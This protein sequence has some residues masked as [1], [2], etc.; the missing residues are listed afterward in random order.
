MIYESGKLLIFYFPQEEVMDI[1]RDIIINII[2]LFGLV[3]VISLTSSS[4]KFKNRLFD[5]ILGIVIGLITI[6]IMMN[7]W[8]MQNIAF[9]DTRTVMLSVTALF[10]SLTTSLVATVF[11]LGYR[12]YIGGL[13]IY[14]GVTSIIFA[15]LVGLIW[16][17]Y[18]SKRLKMNRYL[19]LYL[20]GFLVQ[21]FTLFA[22]LLLPYPLSIEVITGVGLIM[23]LFFPIATMLLGTAILN[24]ENR[25][26]GQRIIQVSERKYRSLIDSSHLGIIQFNEFGVIEIANDAF[27]KMLSTSK[28]RLIGLKQFSLPNKNLVE[29]VKLCLEGKLSTY[30]DYYTSTLSGKTFPAKIQFSPI[31]E[32][33]KV[34][35]GIGIVED[36]TLEY[37]NEERI[38]ELT[39][40]DTLTKICNRATFDAYIF[41]ETRLKHHP[42]SIAIIDI[43]TFQIINT[44]FGYEVGNQVLIQVARTITD[45]IT[46]YENTTVYRT[47]GDEFALVI[48]STERNKAEALSEKIKQAINSLDLFDFSLNVSFGIDT[49]ESKDKSLVEAY[50]QALVNLNTSK[51]YD[52][53]SI[54]IKTI[55]VIMAT[56]F[57]K[58]VRE[59]NHSERVSQIARSIAEVYNLGTAFTNRVELAG[60]L[61][62]IGKINI[63]EDILDKPGRLTDDERL[64]INKHPESGFKILS[65]VSE[66]LD[67]ANIVLSHHE[68]Y[69]GRGY[70]NG[71]MGNKIPL[72]SRIIGVA[73]AFD[74]MTEQRTYRKPLTMGEAIKEISDN[75]G[76]QFDPGVVDKFMIYI[77]NDEL[78]S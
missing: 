70:P 54:S 41:N 8:Q 30:K 25:I 38:K 75:K 66:Y 61:H 19:E 28:E 44:S 18:I 67:I 69:D 3:F 63:S 6:V 4:I 22:Q 58:S 57:E 48:T 60:R 68:R 20:F 47:G 34:I 1:F 7:A 51:I 32:N 21:T 39:Q 2:L 50:N 29:K 77:K 42:V 24:H 45:I 12:I 33:E 49:V 46:P 36:L 78:E 35:G 17:K 10:F 71:L 14:A 43:N 64:K 5:I 16:K 56:L 73:D 37:K 72:E 9:F 11:A 59:K 27:V 52:G 31:F 15:L 65:S 53:S 40:L 74:A 23:L 76:T 13:G 26:E 62:D 55:D